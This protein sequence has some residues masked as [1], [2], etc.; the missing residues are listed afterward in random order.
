M[1]HDLAGASGSSCPPRREDIGPPLKST[2]QDH[3]AYRPD[4]D[5]L[6]AVAVLGVVI[7]HAFPGRLVGGFTGVDVFFVISGYLITNILARDAANGKLTISG[8][9]SRRV[10]RIFPALLAV[11][12]TVLLGGWLLLLASEY[13]LFAKHVAASVGF[14]ANLMFWHEA[15]YFDADSVSNPLLHLWSLGVEEQFY[16]IWPIMIAAIFAWRRS[17]MTSV[18][19]LAGASFM[20]SIIMVMTS[21]TGAFYSPISRF[22]ELLAGA[23]LVSAA[24]NGWVLP[25]K[26]AD[27][28]S[29]VGLL[30]IGVTFQ[31]L[32]P[33]APFPGVAA[34]PPV[35]GAMLVIGCGPE[36][37][38]NR[39]LLSIP[40]AVGIGLI[41][42]PLYLWHWPL[43]SFATIW[44]YEQYLAGTV[45]LAIVATAIVFAGLTYQFVEKPLRKVPP[46][47]LLSAMIGILLAALAIVMTSGVPDRAANHDQR[48]QFIDHYRH[49]PDGGLASFRD[50]CNFV[51]PGSLDARSSISLSCTRRGVNGT[52]FLWGDSHAQ[53]LSSGIAEILP[54]GYALAQVA[55]SG[56]H[57]SLGLGLHPLFRESMRVACDRSNA[58]ALREIQ[59]LKPDLVVIAQNSN[60]LDQNWIALSDHLQSIGAQRTVLIGPLPQWRPSLPLVIVSNNWPLTTDMIATGLDPT[61]V[62][63]DRDL[64][65]QSS[66]WRHL[67]YI[68]FIESLCSAQGCRARVPGGLMA[69]DYGHLTPEGSHYVGQHILRDPIRAQLGEKVDGSVNLLNAVPH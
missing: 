66:H 48:R 49:L 47:G 38:V 27:G 53:S 22:W 9:Y 59:R 31:F 2:A 11:L 57:P 45:R 7:F 35:L 8:F 32:P 43:L 69:F 42:Y 62:T 41:S 14:V 44:N 54:R 24:R 65:T 1:S 5:G 25:A 4:I 63:I 18:L 19:V 34:L 30:L 55:S 33:T 36:A 29:V 56:C 58:L 16:L 52:V 51:Q 61:I 67:R 6:R 26:W 64:L 21:P 17:L 60:Q 20:V 68:S 39:R 3:I 10:K 23:M 12:V 50:E 37:L 40:V 28:A 13:S 15:N 46:F